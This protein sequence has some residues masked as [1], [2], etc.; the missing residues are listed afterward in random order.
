MRS[1]SAISRIEQ[2]RKWQSLP[3]VSPGG[4]N[5]ES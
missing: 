2:E 4:H 3:V 5:T 1:K